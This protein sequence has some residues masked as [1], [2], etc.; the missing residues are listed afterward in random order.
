M[1]NGLGLPVSADTLLR[2]LRRSQEKRSERPKSKSPEIPEEGDPAEP[3]EADQATI[4]GIDDFAF[5]KGQRYGTIVVDNERRVPI[6]LLPDR[7]TETVARWLRDHPGV[8]IVTRDRASSYAD[9]IGKGAP[10]AVQVAD[11]FHLLKNMTDL[12]GRVVTRLHEA[13]RS[14]AL[15]VKSDLA[16]I[17]TVSCPPNRPAT[18]PAACEVKRS[19][20]QMT[21]AEGRR[22]RRLARFH[23]VTRLLSEG[24]SEREVARITGRSRGTIRKFAHLGT[25]PEYAVRAERTQS[26]LASFEEHLRKRW[27]EGQHCA[28]RLHAEIVEMGFTGSQSIVARYVQGWR[29]KYQSDINGRRKRSG[30]A[31]PSPQTCALVLMYPNHSRVTADL[32]TFANKLVGENPEIAT[33]QNHALAFVSLFKDYCP[34]RLRQ[35]IEDAATSGIA[36]LRG[37]AQSLKR[38]HD[39]VEAGLTMQWSNGQTEGQVNRLKLIKRSMYGGCNFDLLRARVLRPKLG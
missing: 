11:R 3:S 20:A 38:D 16:S 33:V 35:W 25:L 26:K 22:S 34:G 36:E 19:P 7:E 21:E 30:F 6:D 28:T 31:V 18:P 10:D 39:A 1:S 17:G 27:D 29:D 13:V 8:K 4:I 2:V 14:S 15:A 32:S 12:V 23:E 37:I 24:R 5:L 9:A